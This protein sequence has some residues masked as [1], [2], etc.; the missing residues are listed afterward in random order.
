MDFSEFNIKPVEDKDVMAEYNEMLK[1]IEDVSEDQVTS[2]LESVLLQDQVANINLSKKD[3]DD[4]ILQRELQALGLGDFSTDVLNGAVDEKEEDIQVT[5][6]DLKNEAFLAE[7]NGL[8]QQESLSDQINREK[9]NALELKRMGDVTGAIEAMRRLKTLEVKYQKEQEAEKAMQQQITKEITDRAIHKA[10]QVLLASQE[11]AMEEDQI[12]VTEEDL[13]D[14]AFADELAMLDRNELKVNKP[15]VDDSS[16]LLDEF[17]M[18]DRD[19]FDMTNGGETEVDNVLHEPKK[20]KAVVAHGSVVLENKVQTDSYTDTTMMLARCKMEAIQHKRDGDITAALDSMRRVKELQTK[21]Q[22]V[23]SGD[24]G[25]DVG[26]MDAPQLQKQIQMKKQSALRLKKEGKK[27]EALAAMKRMKQLQANLQTLE[28]SETKDSL[29][30]SAWTELEQKL[31]EFANKAMVSAK[32]LANVDRSRAKARVQEVRLFLPC[33]VL[34]SL[35]LVAKILSTRTR[36]I[37]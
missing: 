36:K 4:P 1:N 21:L 27:K 23:A 28:N 17:D 9:K 30:R 34:Y 5:E 31:I 24:D 3:M 22:Q 8:T 11:R 33:R 16:M 2:A 12:E 13:M 37:A 10:D 32:E 26:G 18:P 25:Q 14:P 15:V 20:Q 29:T 35:H 19:E 6:E 7:L